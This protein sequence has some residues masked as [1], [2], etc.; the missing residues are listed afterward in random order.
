[1]CVGGDG[2]V[3]VQVSLCVCVCVWVF[4][5]RAHK[6]KVSIGLL[7]HGLRGCLAVNPIAFGAC[8]K[9]PR[10]EADGQPI[11]QSVGQAVS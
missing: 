6:K 5:G 9:A 11:S 1:M 3:G 4:R 8:G 2:C 7:N 10:R